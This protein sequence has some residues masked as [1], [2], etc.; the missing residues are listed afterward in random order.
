MMSIKHQL[1]TKTSTIHHTVAPALSVA[2]VQYAASACEGQ[3]IRKW[4]DTLDAELQMFTVATP[5]IL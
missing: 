4:A 5:F 1:L 3:Y 2:R